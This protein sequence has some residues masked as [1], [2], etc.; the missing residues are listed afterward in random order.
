M[1]ITKISS[2]GQVV[3][4]IKIRADLDIVDGSIIGIEKIKDM[5]IIKKM[6]VDLLKQFNNSLKDLKLGKIK[7]VA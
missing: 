2:K 3:I 7:R 6:D 4:P 5:V 1:E